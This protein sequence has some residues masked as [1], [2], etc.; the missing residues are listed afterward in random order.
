MKK[1]V[2]SSIAILLVIVLFFTPSA[3]AG[4]ETT[5]LNDVTSKHWAF[6][7]INKAIENGYVTGY[8]DG[9][10][11]PKK[12]VTRAEFIKMIVD[13][14]KLPHS[15]GGSP[16]YQGYVSTAF[17]IGL[18][19]EMDSTAYEKP[20]KRIE[21][22]RITSRALS[23]GRSYK[24]Y[25]DAYANLKKTDIPFRDTTLIQNKDVPYIAL[26]YGA[27]II[28][29]FPDGE[30]GVNKT[31]SRAET[32]VMIEKFLAIRFV[33]P[34]KESRLQEILDASSAR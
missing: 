17:E 27:E 21:I 34:S 32:V 8:P 14:L 11:D 18:L 16:W 7:S 29:G 5:K 30:I 20:I 33:S 23:F 6:S 13:A 12:M 31:S 19:D 26:A 1:Q 3:F 24:K 28:N 25:F 9:K 2:L 22:M 15:Q 4:V 10:F